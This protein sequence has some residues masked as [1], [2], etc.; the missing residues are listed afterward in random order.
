MS[1]AQLGSNIRLATDNRRSPEYWRGR[2]AEARA[3]LEHTRD[4]KVRSYLVE[5]AQEYDKLAKIADGHSSAGED[6]PADRPKD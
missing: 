1:T 5:I 2:A 4:P 3:M 6:G